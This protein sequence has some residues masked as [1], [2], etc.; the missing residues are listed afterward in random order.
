M[1]R[2]SQSRENSDLCCTT[3]YNSSKKSEMCR[4]RNKKTACLV[5]YSCRTPNTKPYFCLGLSIFQNFS[6]ASRAGFPGIERQAR[7]QLERLLRFL[8]PCYAPNM[9]SHVSSFETSAK[10]PAPVYRHRRPSTP[11]LE[12]L[13]RF[14]APCYTIHRTRNRM[15]RPGFPIFQNFSKASH[16]G[17]LGIERAVSLINCEPND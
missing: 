9:K 1:H 12:R 3:E 13:P 17:F 14:L 5:F 2:N 6:K 8:P 10:R 7:P 11:K 15:S 4:A 16:A